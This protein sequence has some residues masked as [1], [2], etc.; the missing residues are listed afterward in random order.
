[1]PPVNHTATYIELENN[2]GLPILDCIWNEIRIEMEKTI[3]I[4]FQKLFISPKSRQRHL[5]DS[6]LVNRMNIYVKTE[7]SSDNCVEPF[8][9][10]NKLLWNLRAI[11]S[12]V[13]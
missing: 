2:S 7:T 12:T 10:R 6:L 13:V 9:K 11:H 4:I 8:T 3:L 1:M 5:S